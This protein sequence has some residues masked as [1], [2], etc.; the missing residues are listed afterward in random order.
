MINEWK[1]AK[2]LGQNIRY[3]RLA[4]HMTQADLCRELGVDRA[5]MSN[6]ENG[7]KNPT[8]ATIERVAV[9]LGVST[10]TLLK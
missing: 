9:A 10:N 5:Y 6:L 1:T 7:N 4:R 2:K 3:F 8:L